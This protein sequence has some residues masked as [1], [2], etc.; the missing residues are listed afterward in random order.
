M[1][2]TKQEHWV[3]WRL[4]CIIQQC[5]FNLQVQ[6]TDFLLKTGFRRQ[7]NVLL[8]TP[9]APEP[10]EHVC[11]WL[12]EIWKASKIWFALLSLWVPGI[13]HD[14]EVTPQ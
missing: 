14:L 5:P 6:T 12:W 11:H 13:E 9:V 3:P 10:G 1:N 7:N 2:D 8:L 4:C